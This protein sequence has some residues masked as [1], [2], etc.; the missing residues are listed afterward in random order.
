MTPKEECER[1]LD[2]LLQFAEKQL[3]KH[4]AFYPYGAVLRTDGSIVL[5]AYADERTEF[6]D[7]NHMIQG[8]TKLHKKEAEEG[9]IKASG[10]AWDA[11]VT[12]DHGQKTD[13]V[14]VSLEHI[15]HYAVVVGQPYRIGMFQKLKL[16][17]I[18]AQEGKHEIFD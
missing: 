11:K 10:I 17:E 15:D 14:I 6:P 1:I 16:G 4:G 3:K 2:A 7:P 18:F 8:L 12:T 13:A 9:R 5:T